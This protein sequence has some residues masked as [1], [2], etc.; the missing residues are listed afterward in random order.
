MK[1]SS[2]A[3][4]VLAAAMGAQADNCTAGLKYCGATLLRK[5]DY[6]GQIQQAFAAAG[7][8]P[9]TKPD[10]WRF[11]CL[12]GSQGLIK[13]LGRCDRGCKDNGTGRDDTCL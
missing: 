12:G 11:D 4:F 10:D 8:D 13:L 2:T 6:R 9:Y 5:G 1:F 3:I 7:R